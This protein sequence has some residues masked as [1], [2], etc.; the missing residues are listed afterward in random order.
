MTEFIKKE[1]GRDGR[2]P[3]RGARDTRSAGPGAVQ[4]ANS[5]NTRGYGGRSRY[6]SKASP[7]PSHSSHRVV[8]HTAKFSRM[9]SGKR[10]EAVIEHKIPELKDNIRI[11]HLGGVEEVGKNMSLIE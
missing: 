5:R 1:P 6:P 11:I 9:G 3:G 4:N 8:R 7:T 10:R 2:D